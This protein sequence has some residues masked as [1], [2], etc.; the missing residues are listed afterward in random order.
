MRRAS[1]TWGAAHEPRVVG[2]AGR[3]CEACAESAIPMA[4]L[5]RAVGKNGFGL[6]RWRRS[7]LAD[8]D[9]AIAGGDLQERSAA[10]QLATN[11]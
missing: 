8:A 11:A 7:E 9:A 6:L 1:R 4:E 5:T 3:A 10:V 2:I